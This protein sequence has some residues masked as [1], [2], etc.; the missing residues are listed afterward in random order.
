MLEKLDLKKKLSK[1]AY[2]KQMS[3]LQERLRGLQ[4]AARD[5]NLAVIICLEGWDT[6]GKGEIIKKLT[7][8]LDPRLFRVHQGAPP[9]P[10]ER[11]Y[12]FL[13]R[14][15]T[16]LPAYGEMGMFDHS[17][18]GRVLVERCHKLVP[19][20]VWRQGYEQI[21]EF[22]RWLGDDGQVLIKFWLHISKKEQKKRFKRM[23]A[24]RL[25]SWRIT[26]DYRRQHRT[27]AKWTEAVEE[28]LAKTDTPYAQ[29]SLIEANDVRWA[30]VRVFDVIARRIEDALNKRGAKP[31][32]VA[33]KPEAAHA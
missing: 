27:Y 31:K 10:L 9:T 8:R 22:E 5:A 28:M 18:Y 6:S 16:R 19:K 32:L 3:E 20:K 26:K 13:W 23:L 30:R 4:Y 25:Q 11:R 12:H 15:Q 2:A 33:S 21:N 29:W 7:E 17:W 24:D 14:Y 1:P